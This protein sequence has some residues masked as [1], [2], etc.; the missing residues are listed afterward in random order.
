MNGF[1][2]GARKAREAR[3]PSRIK[4]LQI[5]VFVLRGNSLKRVDRTLSSRADFGVGEPMDPF[6][7]RMLFISSDPPALRLAARVPT[8]S[9]P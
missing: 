4:A 3:N 9:R 7:F 8:Y 2:I 5:R 6:E 1:R